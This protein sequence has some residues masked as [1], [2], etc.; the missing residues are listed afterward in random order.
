[1][2]LPSSGEQRFEARHLATALAAPLGGRGRPPSMYFST[3]QTSARAATAVLETYAKSITMMPTIEAV[4]ATECRPR[5]EDHAFVADLFRS[6]RW[7]WV[8]DCASTIFAHDNRRNCWRR[9]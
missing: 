9:T 7:R 4:S 1:V 5:A 2:K 8:I 3:S 6:G